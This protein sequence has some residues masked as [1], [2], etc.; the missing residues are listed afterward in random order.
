M[1]ED[2]VLKTCTRCA[3]TKALNHRKDKKSMSKC[4]DCGEECTKDFYYIDL[5]VDEDEPEAKN[6]SLLYM[7]VVTS[8]R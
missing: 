1:V 7:S 3:E 8:E 2:A 4:Y 6:Q 5:G